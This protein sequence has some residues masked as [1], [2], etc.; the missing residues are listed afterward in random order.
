MTH[1]DT[2]IF[3]DVSTQKAACPSDESIKFEFKNSDIK[4]LRLKSAAHW[5]DYVALTPI[6][7]DWHTKQ[8][9]ILNDGNSNDTLFKS[10]LNFLDINDLATINHI[11]ED[12][13]RLHQDNVSKL[14]K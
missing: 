4:I 9:A 12:N 14:R 5:V 13:A 6:E 10:V 3:R 8:Q 11:I 1:I 2:N 7:P